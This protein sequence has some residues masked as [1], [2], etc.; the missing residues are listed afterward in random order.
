MFSFMSNTKHA[1]RIGPK[2]AMAVEYVKRHPGCAMLPVADY[3]SPLPQGLEQLNRA[4]G[5]NIVHC[6]VRAGLLDARPGA[7]RGTY[8]LYVMG[9]GVTDEELVARDADIEGR[10]EVAATIRAS[11]KR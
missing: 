1:M 4:Y 5:Y 11:I 2:M 9:D 8:S 6:A 10:H 7:R 3:V